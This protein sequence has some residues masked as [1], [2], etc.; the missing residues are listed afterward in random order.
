MKELRTIEAPRLDNYSHT[1]EG[2]LRRLQRYNK[3]ADLD[4]LR[5]A[6]DVS[7]K[8]HQD[9]FRK[10]GEPYFE[11]PLEVAKILIGLRMDYQTVIGG[12][13]HDVVEDTDVSLNYVEEEFGSDIKQLV[14]GVTKISGL[15][16]LEFEHQ[17]SENFRK[18]MLSMVRDIRVIMI[19]FADRLHNMRTLGSLK[20]EKR[21]RIAQETKQV[22]A[23]LAHRLGLSKIKSELEDLALKYLEPD[24]YE[25]L[26][27]RIRETKEEREQAI[28]IISR[29][30]R[31]ALVEAKVP[32]RFE[33][34]AKHFASIYNK[35]NI[36]GVPFE[37]I[38]DFLAIRIIV[39]TVK[40]CYHALGIVHS[41]YKPINDLFKDYIANPKPN[42]YQSIHT[43]VVGPLGKKYE[44]QIRTEEMHR[45]AEEGIA[46]HWR[47]KEGKIREDDLDRHLLWLRQ[48]LEWD[49]DD[50]DSASF[51]ENLK[52]SLF[53]DEVFVYTPKGDLYKL[54]LNSTPVDF[55]YAVHTD[56]GMHCFAAK[57]NGRIQP[58]S[59]KLKSGDSVEILTSNNQ[60]PNKD[61]LQF[62]ATNRAR[63][64][65]KKYLRDSEFESSVVLGE[66]MLSK[67]VSKYGMKYK[68]IDLSELSEKLKFHNEKQMLAAI[69][70][71][72]TKLETVI[73]RLI[74]EE[75]RVNKQKSPI[76]KILDR[77]RRSSNGVRVAGLD[78]IM[79]SFG[80]CCNP[81]PGEP[82]TG[83]VTKGR[84]IVVHTNSC[85]N[86]IKL[87]QRPERI[88]DVSWDVEQN[89]RFI[90]GI[91][92]LGERRKSFLSEISESVN[93]LDSN[94][95][96]VHM[97]AENSLFSCHLTV[98]VH[99]LSHLQ[100]LINNIKRVNGVIS[101]DR[102]NKHVDKK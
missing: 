26:S 101:V 29:P 10:S 55:A 64:K 56:I 93:A 97:K 79:I 90:S 5:K 45:T 86:L 41:L 88:V 66:E 71:G 12:L 32:S 23:P 30:I 44:I 20:D 47:Y 89:N 28:R 77:A 59:Y 7:M 81:I 51:L 33:G 70:R 15:K 35:I 42:G 65:I 100:K 72:D 63:S 50:T 6:F 80:K 92:V 39:N 9:Q 76:K 58:L 95:L 37:E 57:I 53:Q 36:R 75:K 83:I 19:K 91:Y 52:I 98:E 61:W 85:K 94:I 25:E 62:V 40:E 17:Q 82:I 3:T 21:R 16:L 4:L 14:D 84:G 69:G 102:V 13:L 8:A 27:R 2:L 48:V 18:M 38:F 74:P 78:N 22:Y 31:Q 49:E 24:T 34:R 54:P 73:R 96:D 60:H 1:F 43:T 99:N 11:H 68:E 87:M 67:E 46:A